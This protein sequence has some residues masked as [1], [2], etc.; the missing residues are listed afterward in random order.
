ML[1]STIEGAFPALREITAKG[2]A[3][4]AAILLKRHRGAGVDGRQVIGFFFT[5]ESRPCDYQSKLTLV[6]ATANCCVAVEAECG[7]IS[8]FADVSFW[9]GHQHDHA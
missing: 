9:L 1:I 7:T 6:K 8:E 5:S 4:A 3:G 2:R